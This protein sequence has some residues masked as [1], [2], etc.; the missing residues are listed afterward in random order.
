[1]ANFR[2]TVN[3]KLTEV[4]AW[5]GDMPL[6]YALRNGLGL[7]AAKYGCGQGQCGACTVL[8]NDQP[9][10]SCLIWAVE[11]VSGM[12]GSGVTLRGP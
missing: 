6:L 2:L 11:R 3:G 7:H 1:M 12:V 9:V 4:Q 10:R 5:D 8:L